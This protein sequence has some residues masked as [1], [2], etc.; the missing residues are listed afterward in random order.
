MFTCHVVNLTLRLLLTYAAEKLVTY[1]D[2]RAFCVTLILLISLWN[3]P[4]L[5][6]D[7]F[8]CP[9]VPASTGHPLCDSRQLLLL[10]LW[11]LLLLLQLEVLHLL[12]QLLLRPSTLLK[13]EIPS[14]I[15]A[16]TYFVFAVKTTYVASVIFVQ[17][18]LK[19]SCFNV[20]FSMSSFQCS[21]WS[22]P[23]WSCWDNF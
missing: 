18:L 9:P 17:L 13:M 7:T 19:M 23:F 6:P 1:A 8:H 4:R 14:P 12:L 3:I 5:L 21:C 15:V 16:G 22:M 10:L 2:A 11:L 20:L